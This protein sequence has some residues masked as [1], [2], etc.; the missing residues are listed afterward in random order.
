MSII[1]DALKK[2]QANLQ[3]KDSSQQSTATPSI[4]SSPEKQ[5]A[6]TPSNPP[7]VK[8]IRKTLATIEQE[9]IQKKLQEQKK[10]QTLR[11]HARRKSSYVK[12]FLQFIFFVILLIGISMGACLYIPKYFPQ[13]SFFLKRNNTLTH[14]KTKLTSFVP[15]KSTASPHPSSPVQ[16][17][18]NALTLKGI[19]TMNNKQSAL[20]NDE[21]YE[22]GSMV[23]GKEITNISLDEVKLLDN[24]KI[25]T[26]TITPQNP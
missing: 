10:L 6:N 18:E 2:V 20:I 23:Q 16:S 24:G 4:K 15:Q 8:P 17:P 21:I 25:I 11:K 26:L 12:L 3:Q 13:F 5:P 19:I 22:E 7:S 1:N 9:E 14:L